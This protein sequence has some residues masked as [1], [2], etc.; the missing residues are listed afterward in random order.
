MN[1]QDSVVLQQ[2]LKFISVRISLFFS[3]LTNLLDFVDAL[4]SRLH[5][6][7]YLL[8]ER[9]LFFDLWEFELDVLKNFHRIVFFRQNFGH[10]FHVLLRNV[11][12][13][14]EVLQVG[15]G[16]LDS[17]CESFH[18]SG[19]IGFVSDLAYT[20]RNCYFFQ[21]IPHGIIYFYVVCLLQSQFFHYVDGLSYLLGILPLFFKSTLA[22]WY[23][24]QKVHYGSCTQEFAPD[25]TG[26][27]SLVPSSGSDRTFS[28]SLFIAETL[29]FERLREIL[30]TPS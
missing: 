16:F 24:G 25:G 26:R 22:D 3:L 20:S 8:N 4:L 29:F 12:V 11:L 28:L 2:L 6:W 23:I 17:L 1:R 9:V 13:F 27:S 7:Q 30:L 10:D 5:S 18:D 14:P 21:G 15:K 19:G